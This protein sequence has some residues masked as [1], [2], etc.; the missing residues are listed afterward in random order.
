MS[1][2]NYEKRPFHHK[3]R[4]GRSKATKGAFGKAHP[5][6]KMKRVNLG[7]NWRLG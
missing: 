2:I 6:V 1:L 4:K 5:L 7:H 3:R